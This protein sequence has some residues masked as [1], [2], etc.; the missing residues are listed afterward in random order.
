[1]NNEL[2]AFAR[3]APIPIQDMRQQ[4]AMLAPVFGDQT[5]KYFK[6][7]GDVEY[8]YLAGA[9]KGVERAG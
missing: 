4:A 3:R 7:L 2:K 8:S 1:M 9:C 5:M 6:M